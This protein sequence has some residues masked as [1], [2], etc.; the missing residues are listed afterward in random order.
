MLEF[1]VYPARN[2]PKCKQ[3]PAQT[4]SSAACPERTSFV[5]SATAPTLKVSNCV[6]N[7]KNSPVKLPRWGLLVMVTANTSLA[8]SKLCLFQVFV[9]D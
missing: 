7:A 5:K 4:A 6:L 2:A 9:R 1:A 8:N 3:E